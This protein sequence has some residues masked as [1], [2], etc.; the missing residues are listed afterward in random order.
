[1]RQ[2]FLPLASLALLAGCTTTGA[3]PSPPSL[4]DS[5]WRFTAI[6]GAPPV[7]DAMLSFQGDRLSANVGCNGMGSTWRSESGKLIAGPLVGTKMF[8][9]G[10]MDQERA[11]SD[12][13]GSSPD[14]TLSG[15]RLTLK[16]TAHSA[17]LV[18]K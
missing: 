18:R 1:M 9:E 8:C 15:D 3:S 17:E 14:L 10:K 12:L 2:V 11:V 4:G 16:T 5:E 6:D 7:G 13:L